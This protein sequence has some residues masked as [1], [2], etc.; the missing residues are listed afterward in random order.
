MLYG[1]DYDY[2]CHIVQKLHHISF[3]DMYHS[4][5]YSGIKIAKNNARRLLKDII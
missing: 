5:K 1:H 2:S 3:Y 4:L